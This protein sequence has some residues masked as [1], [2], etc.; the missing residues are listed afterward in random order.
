M[1][2]M[3]DTSFTHLQTLSEREKCV[4]TKAVLGYL[5]KIYHNWTKAKNYKHLALI[6]TEK[7]MESARMP[8]NMCNT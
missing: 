1:A 7:Q 3:P 8:C 5:Q 2:T 6:K 4:N